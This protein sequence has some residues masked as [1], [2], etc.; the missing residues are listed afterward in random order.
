MVTEE[1]EVEGQEEEQVATV[2]REELDELDMGKSTAEEQEV[3]PDNLAQAAGEGMEPNPPEPEEKPA[4]AAQTTVPPGDGSAVTEPKPEETPPDP[5]VILTER[6]KKLEEADANKT[7]ALAAER[8]KRK[9][10]EAL[11]G[12]SNKSPLTSPGEGGE[13]TDDENP[14]AEAKVFAIN[15]VRENRLKESEE[16]LIDEL[17]DVGTDRTEYDQTVS[18][19][20][21]PAMNADPKLMKRFQRSLDPARFAFEEGKKIRE[22]ITPRE[23]VSTEGMVSKTDL[24]KAVAEAVERGRKEI[25]EKVQ[26][27]VKLADLPA[28]LSTI[29]GDSPKPGQPGTLRKELDEL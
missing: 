1:K 6:L 23:P 5:I 11:L 28:S 20:F 2:S 9:E 24:E 16:S 8:N 25:L 26:K 18:Q 14:E 3:T 21:L 17:E 10:L 15:A 12:A 4:E 7:K 19:Y 27:G 29:P 13:I 22:R